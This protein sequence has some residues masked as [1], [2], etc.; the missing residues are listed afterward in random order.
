LPQRLWRPKFPEDA[1]QYSVG[2]KALFHVFRVNKAPKGSQCSQR[3]W[4]KWPQ[5]ASW[6]VIN[7]EGPR[8]KILRECSFIQKRPWNYQGQGSKTDAKAEAMSQ[9][10]LT[11]VIM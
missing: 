11:F 7:N 6:A 3:S 5:V 9:C 1:K 8:Q 4:P 10:N 2:V